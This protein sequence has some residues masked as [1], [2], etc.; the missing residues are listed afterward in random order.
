MLLWKLQV[1]WANPG[2][3]YDFHIAL[4]AQNSQTQVMETNRNHV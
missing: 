3:A 1:Y 2:R 4:P